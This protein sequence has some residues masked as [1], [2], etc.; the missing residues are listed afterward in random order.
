VDTLVPSRPVKDKDAL[1]RAIQGIHA[2]S[3]TNLSGGWLE[4]LGKGEG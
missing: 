1:R 3:N 2:R 4:G